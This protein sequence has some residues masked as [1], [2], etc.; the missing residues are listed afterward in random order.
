MK[1]D[2]RFNGN[3]ALEMLE[4]FS[5]TI[6]DHAPTNNSSYITELVVEGGV[7]FAKG[8]KKTDA[9]AVADIT[10]SNGSRFKPHYHE[11]REV[12]I[13]YEGALKVWKGMEDKFDESDYVLVESQKV[14]ICEPNVPHQVEAV[15]DTRAIAITMPAN[16]H[17]PDA[18]DT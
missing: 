14:F 2:K 16:K 5:G 11:Q 13:V 12:I 3:S 18:R 1:S 6:P 15:G 9:I 8:F 7:G 17:F 10:V 4:L